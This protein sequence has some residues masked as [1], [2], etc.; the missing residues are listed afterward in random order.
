MNWNN[1]REVWKVNTSKKKEI[2]KEELERLIRSRTPIDEI[3][4]HFGVGRGTIYNRI[5]DY[6]DKMT[7]AELKKQ[8]NL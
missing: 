3:M 6:W 2:S 5:A 4:E 1:L 7:Y 8:W